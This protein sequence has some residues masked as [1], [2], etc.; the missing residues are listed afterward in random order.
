MKPTKTIFPIIPTLLLGLIG[1]CTSL[2]MTQQIVRAEDIQTFAAGQSPTNMAF[3]GANI[4]VTNSDADTVTKLRASDGSLQGT[5]PT[6]D[7]PQFAV[8]DGANIWISNTLDD[9]ITR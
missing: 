5:F 3:D 4:W 6:G 9:S 8:F 2:V 7:V 1:L